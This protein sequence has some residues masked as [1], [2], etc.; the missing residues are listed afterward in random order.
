MRNK[1]T[2]FTGLVVFLA[3]LCY[4]VSYTVRYDETAV[5]TFLEKAGPDALKEPG[6]GLKA[7]WPLSKVYTYPRKVQVLEDVQQQIQ[8]SD[9]KSVIVGLYVAW[10]IDQPL[11]FFRTVKTIDQAT[12]RLQALTGEL[13][14]VITQYRFDQLVNPDPSQIKLDEIEERAR[15]V[16]AE[17]ATNYGVAV[18]DVGVRELE[19]P[20]A[21]TQNVFAA[22]R[23]TRESL[24]ANAEQEGQARANQIQTEATSVGDRILAF[25]EREA[26]AIRAEGQRD[27]V[28]QFDVF[29][30][31]PE[32]AIFL[33]QMQMLREV[34]PYRTTFILDANELEALS[35]L[36]AEQADGEGGQQ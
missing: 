10:T 18:A 1:A 9:G 16:L 31:E 13:P 19:L 33:R 23:S 6:F 20:E 3:L 7:P 28:E 36:R 5:V 35:P 27:A 4:T 8:T 24:A 25:A 29:A 34:L 32:L 17:R 22:M 30:E 26:T 2:F 12:E 14:A 15:E 11:T 21:V